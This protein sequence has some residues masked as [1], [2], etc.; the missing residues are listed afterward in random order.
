MI[1][2]P[3]SNEQ[4]YARQHRKNANPHPSRHQITPLPFAPPNFGGLVRVEGDIE[5]WVSR[6]ELE[7]AAAMEAATEAT[8]RRS[9]AAVSEGYKYRTTNP[10]SMDLSARSISKFC[11]LV[12]RAGPLSAASLGLNG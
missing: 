5:A 10:R 12:E 4:N 6:A 8:R 3:H 2:P 7:A 1:Q 11:T 9:M